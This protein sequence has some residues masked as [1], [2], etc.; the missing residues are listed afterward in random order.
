MGQGSNIGLVTLL[1]Y[2]DVFVLW[3]LYLRATMLEKVAGFG[4]GSS[5][6][7]AGTVLGLWILIRVALAALGQM[8]GG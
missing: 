7:V 2:V 5:W 8:F 4:K 3:G 6:A 1:S